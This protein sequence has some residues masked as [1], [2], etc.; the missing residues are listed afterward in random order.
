MVIQKKECKCRV[1]IILIELLMV[2]L[3]FVCIGY[4]E[5]EESKKLLYTAEGYIEQKD[6]PKAIGTLNLLL[7]EYPE[8]GVSQL[9][10]IELGLCHFSLKEY[11]KAEEVFQK[12]L[13]T[14]PEMTYRTILFY[15]S[16]T[17]WKLGKYKEALND[18]KEVLERNPD[19]EMAASLHHFIGECCIK[20]KDYS[21]AADE[22]KAVINS[23]PNSNISDRAKDLLTHLT[24]G[25]AAQIKNFYLDDITL[26]P[27][28]KSG[29]DSGYFYRAGPT[30]KN[31][32]VE[33]KVIFREA[34]PFP[35]PQKLNEIPPIKRQ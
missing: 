2:L 32:E 35:Y 4:S 18:F 16:V 14:A 10:Q 29:P 9:A 15:L 6:Y 24:N 21:G 13:S 25:T 33:K 27:V 8:S 7:K 34:P 11:N 19:K 5:E 3:V 31:I 17:Q 20:L 23:S 12:L 28:L 22:F 1:D 26:S 30:S